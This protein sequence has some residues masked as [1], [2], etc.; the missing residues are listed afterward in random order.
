VST[1]VTVTSAEAY[2]VA[3]EAK[4]AAPV[5]VAPAV[6]STFCAVDQFCGVKV[7]VPPPLTARPELPEVREVVTVTFALGASDSLRP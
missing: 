2:P 3:V 4:V 7:R 6:I 5:P 1:W